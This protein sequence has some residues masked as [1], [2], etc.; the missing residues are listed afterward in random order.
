SPRTVV[1]QAH[2]FFSDAVATGGSFEFSGVAPLHAYRTAVPSRRN[3]GDVPK[4]AC[5][6]HGWDQAGMCCQG[7]VVRVGIAAVVDEYFMPSRRLAA[8]KALERMAA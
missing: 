4:D 8:G 6:N 5:G 7:R 2:G 3:P 1:D